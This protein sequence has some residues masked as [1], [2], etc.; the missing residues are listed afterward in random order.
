MVLKLKKRS[1]FTIVL[2]LNAHIS[3][4]FKIPVTTRF[5]TIWIEWIH[6]WVKPT[7][8]HNIFLDLIWCLNCCCEC[9]STYTIKLQTHCVR[10]NEPGQLCVQTWLAGKLQQIQTESDV[11]CHHAWAMESAENTG[12]LQYCFVF[13]ELVTVR[14]HTVGLGSITWQ[15]LSWF[16]WLLVSYIS[17]CMKT[18]SRLWFRAVKQTWKTCWTQCGPF[19]AQHCSLSSDT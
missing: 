15:F 16:F 17:S 13:V 12:N 2:F 14:C 5:C 18:N 9:L 4:S 1:Q 10:S 3:I 19:Q 7:F 6:D 8:N 11:N